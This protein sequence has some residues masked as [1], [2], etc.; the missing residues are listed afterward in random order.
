MKR[1]LEAGKI[2]NTHGIKGE[3]KI[4][5]WANEPAFLCRFKKLYIAEKPYEVRSARV[6]KDCVIASLSG[7]STVEDAEMLRNSVVFI[8][9]EDAALPEGKYFLQDIVGLTAVNDADGKIVGR[10]KEVIEL[11]SNNVYVIDGAEEILIPAVPDYVI[12]TDIESGIIRIKVPE[13]E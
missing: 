10:V 8:D 4:Q 2:V 5:P 6:H 1:Y 9:R 3:V 13:V 11:P 7:V 12:S